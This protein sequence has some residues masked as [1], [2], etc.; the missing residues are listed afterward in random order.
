MR[1]ATHTEP[2]RTAELLGSL[3]PAEWEELGREMA[4]SFGPA[5][6]TPAALEAFD[7]LGRELDAAERAID[8]FA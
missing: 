3:T 1:Y 2:T 8:P 7:L 4:Q 5:G 6:W